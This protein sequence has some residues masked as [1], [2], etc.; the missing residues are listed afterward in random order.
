MKQATSQIQNKTMED[1]KDYKD[2]GIPNQ[3]EISF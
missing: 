3:K 2:T 1:K